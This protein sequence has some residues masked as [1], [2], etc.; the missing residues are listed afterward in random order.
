MFIISLEILY[1]DIKNITFYHNSTIEGDVYNIFGNTLQSGTT[2]LKKKNPKISKK[3][4][5]AKESKFNEWK[6]C[7]DACFIY[8]NNDR[9]KFRYNEKIN[10]LKLGHKSRYYNLMIY[11]HDNELTPSQI[12]E[13]PKICP[14]PKTK[15]S[16][17]VRQANEALNK[18]ITMLGY[19]GLPE[20]IKFIGLDKSSNK[21]RFYILTENEY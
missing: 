3:T 8:T 5:V 18:K 21:Y 12:K 1:R 2:K 17:V 16:E 6:K 9:I 14:T 11:L 10:D 20:N 19:I 4:G 7:G 13:M 15:P